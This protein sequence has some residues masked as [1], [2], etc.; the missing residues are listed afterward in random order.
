MDFT[1]FFTPQAIGSH[2]EAAASEQIPF[3]GSGGLFGRKKKAGL[4]LSW[5]KG[6]KG[7]PVSLMPSAFDAKATFRDRPG[8]EKLETE[9]PFFR[10]GFHIKERD[11]QE[12]LRAQDANDPYLDEYI[13]N[14]FNDADNL[15]NG[16]NVVPE[17][18]IWQ[19]LCPENGQPGIS[20]TTNGVSYVYNYDPKSA[21]KTNNYK[22]VENGWNKPDQADPF[23]DF[24]AAKDS[25]RQR[26]GTELTRAVMSTATFNMLGATKA[27]KDRFLATNGLSLGYI[28]DDQVRD[29]VTKTS[30][31][32]IA[33]YDKLYKDEQG[34]SKAY[35]PDGY[36]VMVPDGLLGDIW[37][38]TTPEEADLMGSGRAEVYVVNTGVA[39]T[40]EITTHPVNTNIYASE[41]VLPSWERMDE[42]YLLKVVGE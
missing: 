42:C 20:F 36:V 12:M 11:R 1:N 31:L 33:V 29:I 4:D 40:T 25:V 5:F 10:E 30:K 26:T 23:K 39:I 16:A 9:M 18:M 22:E 21:W 19:L 7:L 35:V 24:K 6:S 2:W 14:T 34:T 27:L 41:I 28:T 3:L 38:G 15:I 37:Y 32:T 13:R 8:F 17:R